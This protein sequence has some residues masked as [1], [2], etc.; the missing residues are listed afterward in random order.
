MRWRDVVL[1]PPPVLVA[2]VLGAVMG[3]AL[4]STPAPPTRLSKAQKRVRWFV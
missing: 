4:L 2:L 1:P 3:L